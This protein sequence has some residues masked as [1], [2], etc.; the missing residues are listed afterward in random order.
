MGGGGYFPAASLSGVGLGNPQE[1]NEDD[2]RPAIFIFILGN[3]DPEQ[4]V[5]K[6]ASA[7]ALPTL[8]QPERT[9]SRLPSACRDFSWGR[10]DEVFLPHFKPQ[11]RFR[12]CCQSSP[13]APFVGG[14]L[15]AG[16]S[17]VFASP[18]NFFHRIEW[19]EIRDRCFGIVP[20]TCL[21]S[22]IRPLSSVLP[23]VKSRGPV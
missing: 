10:M 6:E 3:R 14:I 19:Q 15:R 20:I 21:P 11:P 2:R 8:R 22:A 5:V 1:I 18:I 13:Y 9:E 16:T 17:S 7:D 12:E 23:L 4:P